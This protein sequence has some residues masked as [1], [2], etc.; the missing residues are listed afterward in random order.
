[1]PDKDAGISTVPFSMGTNIVSRP[2]KKAMNVASTPGFAI[3][4]YESC[5][6][7]GLLNVMAGYAVIGR[8]GFV[9]GHETMRRAPRECTWLKS[10]GA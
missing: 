6:G 7:A 8:T 4:M 10:S 3:S 9:G 1:M 5:P 2:V